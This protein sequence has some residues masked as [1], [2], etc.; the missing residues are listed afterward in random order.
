MF[1]HR[2]FLLNP[3]ENCYGNLNDINKLSM[4]VL[5]IYTSI[6]FPAQII[7]NEYKV[8]SKI[9]RY[10]IMPKLGANYFCSIIHAY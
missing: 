3:L 7:T 9:N 1:Q 4:F 6:V 8:L 10:K 5:V 2:Y